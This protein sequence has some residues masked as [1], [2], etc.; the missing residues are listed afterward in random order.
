MLINL[1]LFIAFLIGIPELVILIGMVCICLSFIPLLFPIRRTQI[2]N[3]EKFKTSNISSHIVANF[4]NDYQIWKV[5]GHFLINLLTL[6]LFGG[7]WYLFLLN[8]PLSVFYIYWY[9]LFCINKL[10]NNIIKINNTYIS[11]WYLDN[12]L[13]DTILSIIVK[14]QLKKLLDPVKILFTYQDEEKIH[15]GILLFYLFD[16]VILLFVFLYNIIA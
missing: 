15:I 16:M 10:T 7:R 11:L 4:A 12:S 9:V 5:G 14:K 6:P 8:L 13:N 3:F 1:S 2:S